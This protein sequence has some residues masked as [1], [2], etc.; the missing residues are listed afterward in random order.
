MIFTRICDV[1]DLSNWLSWVYHLLVAAD[2]IVPF[3]I[4]ADLERTFF[5]LLG[6]VVGVICI[7]T[8]D[9]SQNGV[10]FLNF[11]YNNGFQLSSR[12]FQVEEAY[13]RVRLSLGL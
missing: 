8:Q 3:M 10:G 11:S 4:F 1:A 9:A 13:V 7:S 5:E 12:S 6:C 2:E